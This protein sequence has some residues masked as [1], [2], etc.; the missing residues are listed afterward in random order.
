MAAAP[1]MSLKIFLPMGEKPPDKIGRGY[2]TSWY[3]QATAFSLHLLKRV[4]EE[5]L[6]S[7]LLM[8]S[9][10]ISLLIVIFASNASTYEIN[11][12]RHRLADNPSL[13]RGNSTRHQKLRLPPHIFQTAND[14]CHATLQD[15]A[16]HVLTSLSPRASIELPLQVLVHCE[17]YYYYLNSCKGVL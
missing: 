6:A 15:F 1:A 3:Q 14:P 16:R 17:N 11:N 9:S 4:H 12:G 13:K 2:Y 7:V 5:A 8:Q 10:T